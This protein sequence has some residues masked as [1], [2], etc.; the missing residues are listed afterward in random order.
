MKRLAV[1]IKKEF[2]HVLR[3]RKTLLILF[4]MPLVQILIFGF[5]LSNEVK[6]TN[7]LVLDYAQDAA[8]KEIVSK[9]NASQYFQIQEVSFDAQQIET[10]FQ[11]DESKAAIVFPKD[12]EK[13]LTTKKQASVQI[14][15]D[16]SDPNHATTIENYLTAIIQDYTA[17][18][19]GKPAVTIVPEV[20]MLYNP[21]LKGA[22]NFVPGVM[23][24]ILMLVCVLM[25]AISIVREKEMG[26]MEILLVSPFKP[27]MVIVSKVIPYFILSLV[28]IIS[29][30]LLSVYVLQVPIKGN[31]FLLFAVSALFIM[32]CLSLGIFISIKTKTQQVAMLISLMGMLLPTILFSGFMFPIENMPKILQVISNIIPAKWYYIIVKDV[33]IKGLGFWAVWKESL[34]LFGITVFFLGISIKNFKIRLS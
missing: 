25:T 33:M 23:A 19:G 32:T 30:L 11:R 22:P 4:G 10:A 26:T 20:R 17:S 29:I 27:I 18:L 28:N 21:Q 13:D 9:I 7:L 12:F 31:I 6:N 3:D 34:I 24:L 5:V 8:S 16:A 15:A 1:F 14:I 2:I